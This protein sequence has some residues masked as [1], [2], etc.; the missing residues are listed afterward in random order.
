MSS[1]IARAILRNGKTDNYKAIVHNQQCQSDVISKFVA[2][3]IDR[4]VRKQATEMQSC[5][6]KTIWREVKIKIN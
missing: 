2:E 5:V 6:G 4:S 3:S 1:V